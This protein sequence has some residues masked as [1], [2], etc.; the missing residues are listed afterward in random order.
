[1]AGELVQ[2]LVP[3]ALAEQ[4]IAMMGVINRFQANA[5]QADVDFRSAEGDL[6]DAAAE[7]EVAAI[8]EMLG[9][10][11]VDVPVVEVDGSQWRKLSTPYAENYASLRGEVRVTRHLYRKMGVR[12]GPTIVPMELRAGIVD[13]RYTPTAAEALAHLNQA[14]PSREADDLARCLRVLPYSRSTQFRGAYVVGERWGDLEE[15]TF[16]RL[17][18]NMEIP[19]EAR[20]VTLSVDR[21]TL[22]MAEDRELTATDVKNGIKKPIMVAF[23]M[24]Y[25]ACF[26][27]NDSQGKTLQCVRYAHVPKDGADAVVARLRSDAQAL[28][29]RRPDLKIVTLA[30]GAPEMQRL[31]DRVVEGLDVSAQ[32]V[33]FWHLAE[34]LCA[35]AK[36]VGRNPKSELSTFRAY[37]HE[38]ES[39]IEVVTMRLK[40][41]AA[42]CGADPP[43]D[44]TAAITY[45]SN[46]RDRM[47]YAKAWHAGFPIGSG[48]VEATAK[49]I[50]TTRMKRTGARWKPDGAQALLDLRAL[51]TSGPGRWN[52]A[53][54]EVLG[55]YRRDVRV[56]DLPR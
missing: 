28:L 5:A 20:S 34:Y 46:H 21:A 41:W 30:D 29:K 8:R 16:D 36:C 3:A 14:V 39:G 31:L 12:N 48:A 24:A 22:P 38:W 18:D 10:L 26:T 43:Q 42:A 9:S 35:A 47:N 23:R 50:I 32:L 25:T 52:A 44:L 4:V 15:E 40:E 55:G 7:L 37:L 33:D 1:M 27:L 2:V 54:D 49:T 13:G 11:D 51:A 45:T 6:L 56:V 19:E 17:I 53:M